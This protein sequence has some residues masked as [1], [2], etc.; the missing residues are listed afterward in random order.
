[1]PI[2]FDESLPA[3]VRFLAEQFGAE[4]VSRAVM[5]RDAS[6]RL[7]VYLDM[8]LD[9]GRLRDAQAGFSAALGGY[10]KPYSLA[11]LSSPAAPR[12]LE[13]AKALMPTPV[14]D[15]GVR[16]IERRIVG[17]EWMLPPA[18]SSRR[19]RITFAS[20]KGGVGRST[21]LCVVAAHLSMRGRRVLAI[22]FD[23]EAP[24]IGT[25]LLDRTELPLFGTID[26]LVENGLSGIDDRFMADLA[27]QSYLGQSGA[28]VAVVPAIGKKT[29]E[30][31]R[32]ALSK[33]A[34]AYLE[35]IRDEG[36]PATL[37][38]QL[39]A[40]VEG[41]EATRAYDVVLVDARAG[42]HESSPAA[43]FGL[44]GDALL[45]GLDMPQTYLGYSLLMAHLGRFAVD[46]SDDWRERLRFVH[47]R[48]PDV[49]ASRESAAERFR[50][51]YDFVAP[52]QSD[53]LPDTGLTANDFDVTWVAGLEDEVE[54]EFAPPEV[55]YVL[56]DGRYRDFDPVQNRTLLQSDTYAATFKKLIEYADELVSAPAASNG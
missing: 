18:R 38:D 20:L 31:P 4:A 43:L 29:L 32:D 21:A 7:G 22:D 51:L 39:R 26:Y 1:M 34:R 2:R 45:F 15:L 48:A 47:A 11:D 16:L 3:A 56:D 41:F 52:R 8:E 19:T 33:L 46:P 49:N 25:M 23:L 36:R 24:G 12:F 53:V 42:L 40:L 37:S 9:P 17:S 30:N 44:G 27:A 55:S 13:E 14:G 5:I 28:P 50:Q 10:S 35:D 54:E 6:G